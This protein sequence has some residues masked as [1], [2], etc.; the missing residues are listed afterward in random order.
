LTKIASLPLKAQA[1]SF[2]EN[3]RKGHCLRKRGRIYRLGVGRADFGAKPA[4]YASLAINIARLLHYLNTK[5]AE[6]PT[7]LSYRRISQEFNS[8]VSYRLFNLIVN[9]T[10]RTPG[11][12]ICRLTTKRGAVP[13]DHRLF[14]Y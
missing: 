9:Y 11:A 14:L 4:S 5:I 8:R 6:L 10:R 2:I 3:V 7:K 1:T 12:D 13:T